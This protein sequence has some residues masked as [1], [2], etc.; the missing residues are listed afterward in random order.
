MLNGVFVH[1]FSINVMMQLG[2][3]FSIL[4]RN[5]FVL[6]CLKKIHDAISRYNDCENEIG[7]DAEYREQ[8]AIDTASNGGYKYEDAL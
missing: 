7:Q 1:F 3:A 4:L 8:F 6:R 5:Q 2:A